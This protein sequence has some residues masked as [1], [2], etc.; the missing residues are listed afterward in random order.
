M[1]LMFASSLLRDQQKLRQ[2]ML[3][4]LYNLY[5]ATNKSSYIDPFLNRAAN[6]SSCGWTGYGIATGKRALVLKLTR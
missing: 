5:T 1:S 2:Y 4:K 3:W 6:A